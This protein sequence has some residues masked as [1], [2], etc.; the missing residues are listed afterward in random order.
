VS[1]RAS[2]RASSVTVRA[3]AIIDG[4]FELLRIVAQLLTLPAVAGRSA[5][6]LAA[7]TRADSK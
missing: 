1:C 4:E 7:L 3:E 2:L 5:N 6:R